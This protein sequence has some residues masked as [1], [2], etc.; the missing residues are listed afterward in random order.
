[1]ITK[2]A[3]CDAAYKLTGKKSIDKIT[4]K[5]IVE[6]CQITRQT[7][8]YHFQDIAD[9]IEYSMEREVKALVSEAKSCKSLEEALRD[10]C[11]VFI[12]DNKKLIAR[13]L[14]S[15]YYE[16]AMLMMVKSLK[17]YMISIMEDQKV[18]SNLSVNDMKF[19]IDYHS[20]AIVSVFLCWSREKETD[21]EA[22][23]RQI[24]HIMEGKLHI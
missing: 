2:N 4:V 6:E 10:F 3:I 15:S 19:M 11:N 12:M 16:Q 22:G 8:Y 5:D 14:V 21:M 17:Q 24:V 1:M 20:Y 18:Q 9:M 23:I 13:I 7:F